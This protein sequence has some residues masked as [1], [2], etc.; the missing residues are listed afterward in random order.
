VEARGGHPHMAN[1]LD[2]VRSRQ[3]P[4]FPADLGYKAM[5]AIR[6]GVDAYRQHEVLFFDSKR[7]KTSRSMIAKV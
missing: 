7:E 1:F 6:M 5:T 3:E 4:N 2:A